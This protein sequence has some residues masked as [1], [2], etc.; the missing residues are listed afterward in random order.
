MAAAVRAG[1]PRVVVPAE[2]ALEASL[3]PGADVVPVRS[4]AEVVALHRGE[5]VP[6]SVPVALPDHQDR[7][8]GVDLS[9]VVGQ[10]EGRHALEVAAAGG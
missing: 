4:L 2:A 10:D 8:G 9:D 6:D 1:Y 5:L 7:L 3:V